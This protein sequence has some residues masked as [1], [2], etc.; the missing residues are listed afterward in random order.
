MARLSNYQ[1]CVL[2][3]S[4]NDPWL[5]EAEF[6]E[7]AGR[8]KWILRAKEALIRKRLMRR[9]PIRTKD[10]TFH[11]LTAEGEALA[12]EWMKVCN[13]IRSS[14]GVCWAAKVEPMLPPDEGPAS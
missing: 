3:D 14:R 4:Y 2:V 6:I 10:E 7:N 12:L 11:R 1:I 8:R 9:K 13:F 5:V